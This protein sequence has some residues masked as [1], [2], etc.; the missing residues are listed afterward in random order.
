MWLAIA[1]HDWQAF[2]LCSRDGE[3]YNLA[4]LIEKALKK[5]ADEHCKKL[6]EELEKKLK[7]K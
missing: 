2:I 7:K 6:S 1:T 5:K 3:K 4:E